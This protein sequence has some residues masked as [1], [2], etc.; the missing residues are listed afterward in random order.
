MVPKSGS[1]KFPLFFFVFQQ[2]IFEAIYIYYLVPL[3]IL[4]Y[5]IPMV[6]NKAGRKAI[7]EDI[8]K[9][10]ILGQKDELKR[11]CTTF[12]VNIKAKQHYMWL[13]KRITCTL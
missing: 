3:W 8:F 2:T 13:S 9:H 5:V 11:L 4:S 12:E 6:K 1:V 10:C 7:T